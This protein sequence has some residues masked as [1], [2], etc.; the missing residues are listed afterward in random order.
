MMASCFDKLSMRA[1]L[2][3]LT[4][5]LSSFDAPPDLILSLSKGEVGWALRMGGEAA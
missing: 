4:L 1:S 5:S 2:Q 3:G